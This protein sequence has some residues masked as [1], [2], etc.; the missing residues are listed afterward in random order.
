MKIEVSYFKQMVLHNNVF[1]VKQ[2]AK[3]YASTYVACQNVDDFPHL[4]G[5]LNTQEN[6]I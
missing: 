4:K 3:V 5:I 2:P 1:G 6:A